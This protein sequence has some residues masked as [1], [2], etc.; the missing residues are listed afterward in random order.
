MKPPDL[1]LFS[2]ML[3]STVVSGESRLGMLDR[4]VRSAERLCEGELYCLARRG[5]ISALCLLY[6][7]YHRVDH[8][9]NGYLNSF[10][11]ARQ[12]RI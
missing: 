10:V 3:V 1:L 8:S 7:L 12:W 4:I 9:M 11:A 2:H 5:K 6:E